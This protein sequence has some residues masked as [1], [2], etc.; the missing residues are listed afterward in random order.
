MFFNPTVY[1][2]KNIFLRDILMSPFGL[3]SCPT[4]RSQK[5]PSQNAPDMIVRGIFLE[6]ELG[7]PV[8]VSWSLKMLR[9]IKFR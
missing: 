4:K 2:G 7:L 5:P 6:N 8:N 1:I 3:A 9:E